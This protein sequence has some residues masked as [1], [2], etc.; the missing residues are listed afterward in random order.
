[1]KNTQKLFAVLTLVILAFGFL[2]LLAQPLPYEG[3]DWLSYEPTVYYGDPYEP[4]DERRLAKECPVGGLFQ[5]HNFDTAGD[6]D[7][8]WFDAQAGLP[9][10][11]ET[12]ARPMGS[13]A[14]TVLELYDRNGALLAFDDDGGPM[15]DSLLEFEASYTG[16]YYARVTEWADRCGDAYWY[17]LGV[18]GLRPYQVYLPLVTRRPR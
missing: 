12:R 7:W 11:I 5:F 17:H 18:S 16:V 2:P 15:T 4:D 3:L 14:D 8:I 1:M 10:A 13:L 6:Q 9:Y